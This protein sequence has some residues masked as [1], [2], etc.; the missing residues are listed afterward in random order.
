LIAKLAAL[1][2]VPSLYMFRYHVEAGGLASYGNSL[3]ENYRPGAGYV[4]RILK[5]EKPG[6]LP[7]QAPTKFEFLIN[8]DQF[9]NPERSVSTFRRRCFR[10]PTR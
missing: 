1:H 6:D 10:S 3:A 9:H 4:E 2:H 5:G 8:S 7:V